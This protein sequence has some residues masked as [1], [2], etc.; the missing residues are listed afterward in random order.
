MYVTIIIYKNQ[1]T[2]GVTVSGVTRPVTFATHEYKVFTQYFRYLIWLQYIQEVPMY[3]VI[4][5][6]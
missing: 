4:Q 5:V 2:E 3:Y 6:E 1:T